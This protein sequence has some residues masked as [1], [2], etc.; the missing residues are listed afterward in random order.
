[1][2]TIDPYEQEVLEAYESGALK[3]VAGKA[4]LAK[5]KAA[6]RATATPWR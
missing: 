6:A 5:L 3:A 4:E 1:M 2:A